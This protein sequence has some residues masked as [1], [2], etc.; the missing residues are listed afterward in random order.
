VLGFVYLAKRGTL[1][2]HCPDK[3]CDPEGLQAIGALRLLEPAIAVTVGAGVV[4]IGAGVLTLSLSP[5]IPKK[6]GALPTS[7]GSPFVAAEY[8]F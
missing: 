7:I 1:D 6:Q 4:G 3:R 2:D 5:P 8:R